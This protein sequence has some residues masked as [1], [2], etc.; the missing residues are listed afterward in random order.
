MTRNLLEEMGMTT[1]Q[2]IYENGV[3]RPIR[4]LPLAEGETVEIILA[5]PK[6]LPAEPSETEAVQRI[7]SARTLE[8]WIAAANDTSAEEDGYD[9]LQALE[10]NRKLAGDA[11]PL[12]PTEVPGVAR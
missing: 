8:E 6:S 5:P 9:L 7:R 2:A 10:E 11:R 1:F 3:L 4:P 12:F